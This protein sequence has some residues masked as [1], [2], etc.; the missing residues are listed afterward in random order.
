MIRFQLT[1]NNDHPHESWFASNAAFD[2]LKGAG[3]LE[4]PVCG[5]RK[6]DKALM[7]PSVAAAPAE[8]AGTPDA[9][10]AKLAA[11]RQHVEKHSDYVGLEFVTEARA[12]HEGTAPERPIWGEAR[13]D[14]AKKLLDEGI[15]VAP[16]PFA[17]RSKTN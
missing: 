9:L 14:E 13:I 2:G 3:Q 11:W 4:C 1:C 5:S 10:A 16:L 8:P 6:V 12:I 7:A 15:P 17:P